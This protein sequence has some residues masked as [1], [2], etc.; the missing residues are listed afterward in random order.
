MA[1]KVQYILLLFIISCGVKDSEEEFAVLISDTQFNF[2]QNTNQL[3]VSTKVQPDLDGRIL[4]K[5][6]VEWFGTSL[7]NTPDSLTLFDD[8]TNGDILSNDD[9]YT[10]KVR[11]DSLNIKNTLGDDSGSVHINVLAM[12]IGENANEQSSFRIGNIIPRIINVQA[13]TL[14]TRPIGATLSL[15]IVSATVFDADGLDNIGGWVL[16]H[17]ILK[18]IQ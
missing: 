14:I 10:L 18:A 8:G 3:F 9:Y 6:I 4:D 1:K 17:I 5:V 11:N 13:D 16:L 2:H 15:H 12:Y 7:E